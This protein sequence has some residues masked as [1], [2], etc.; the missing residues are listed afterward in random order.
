MAANI[1]NLP[2]R[3]LVVFVATYFTPATLYEEKV[4]KSHR[5]LEPLKPRK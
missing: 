3:N 2:F 4:E 1:K 5:G